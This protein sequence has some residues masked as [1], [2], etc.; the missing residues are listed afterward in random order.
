M[1]ESVFQEKWQV[2]E[3]IELGH[4]FGNPGAS[5]MSHGHRRIKFCILKLGKN[6]RPMHPVPSRLVH[7][8]PSYTHSN[9]G[10]NLLFRS[11]WTTPVYDIAQWS[12][13]EI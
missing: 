9:V 10:K 2:A 13:T 7:A 4:A 12:E 3:I 11:F 1:I 5:P 8:L 6:S